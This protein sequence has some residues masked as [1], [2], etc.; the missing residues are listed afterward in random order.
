[1]TSYLV[2]GGCGFIGV[3]VVSRLTSQGARVRVL[4]DLSLGKREDIEHPGPLRS[5]PRDHV[6]AD[7]SASAGHE[8]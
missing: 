7:K 8:V 2:T 1:M 3:N 5:E 4:D 6:D